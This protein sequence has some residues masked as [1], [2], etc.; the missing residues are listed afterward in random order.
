MGGS[1]IVS[2]ASPAKTKPDC[3]VSAR[4]EEERGQKNARPLFFALG[5]FSFKFFILSPPP[6]GS[7]DFCFFRALFG[8]VVSIHVLTCKVNR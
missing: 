6:I 7:L 2:S 8:Y 1:K 5:F 3:R 4:A